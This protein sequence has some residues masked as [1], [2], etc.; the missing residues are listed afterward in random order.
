MFDT[1]I[2][3]EVGSRNDMKKFHIFKGA[4]CFYSGYFDAALTGRSTESQSGHIRLADEDPQI[5]ELFRVWIHTRR[6]YESTLAPSQLL[7]FD[8][9]AAL[10][11]FSDAHVVPLLQNVVSDLILE[12]IKDSKSFPSKDDLLYIYHNTMESSPLQR[13]VTDV[14]QTLCGHDLDWESL[15]AGN[16]DHQQP[17]SSSPQAM[18]YGNLKLVQLRCKYHI[19]GDGTSCMPASNG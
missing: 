2:E 17:S 8:I 4:L 19:H 18:R 12:K 13:L 5:F 7:S 15:I 6:F 16:D 3:V 10:W 1:L 9:L 14:H 11:V